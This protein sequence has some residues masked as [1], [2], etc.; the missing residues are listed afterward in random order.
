VLEIFGPDNQGLYPLPNP[1]ES[2]TIKD[3]L[4]Q[5]PS[6]NYNPGL[7]DFLAKFY[8]ADGTNVPTF[9]NQ[10]EEQ[11]QT[12]TLMA[13]NNWPEV[14]ILDITHGNKSVPACA[15]ENMTSST[16][17][18]KVKFKAFDNEGNLQAYDLLALWGTD[19]AQTITSDNYAAHSATVSWQGETQKESPLFKPPVTC[20][21]EFR[22]RAWPKTTNGWSTFGAVEAT[23]HVTLIVPGP[24]AMPMRLIETFPLGFSAPNK[25]VARGV[26]PS[27]LGKDTI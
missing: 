23:K 13:D 6:G 11:A 18:V 26:E 20:A 1:S 10:Q 4:L 9:S 25:M 5:W 7:H 16:D 24:P 27:K 2:Y 12:L 14:K 3:L 8:K 15:I 22:V 17:G 19:Q 21:Y